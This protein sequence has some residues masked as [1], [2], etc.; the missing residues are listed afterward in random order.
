MPEGELEPGGTS[1]S[2]EQSNPL[3]LCPDYGLGKDLGWES[4]P[5]RWAK[6]SPV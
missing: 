1:V 3:Q 4:N 6:P 5:R 2:S